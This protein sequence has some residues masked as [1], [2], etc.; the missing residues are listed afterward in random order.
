[1]TVAVVQLTSVDDVDHNLEQIRRH[2]GDA[3][4]AGATFVALP[5]NATYLRW[6]PDDRAPMQPVEGPGATVIGALRDLAREHGI[7]LLVGSFAEVSPD[8]DHYYNTSVLIDG[9]RDGAPVAA[10][11]RKLHLFD[12]DIVGSESQRESDTI[13]RGD[14]VVV[15]DVRGVPTGLSICYDLRFPRLYQRLV[16]GGARMIAVPS[17]FTEF[18]GKDH[19]MVL[20]RARAIETQTFVIAPGQSGFH[21][22]KRRSYGKSAI[23]DPWGIVLATAADGPGFALARIDFA[24]QDRIRASLPCLQHRHP[25]V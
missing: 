11:Y 19:W 15:A 5:E 18:T 3:A 12:I 24:A 17:A 4:R 10:T 22:G 14:E 1:M 13:A 8:P 16:D 7:W 6:R 20:L 23:V 2:V 9:T 21:G 25:K